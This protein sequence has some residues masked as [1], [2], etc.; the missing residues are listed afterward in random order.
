L[1]CGRSWRSSAITSS[2]LVGGSGTSALLYDQA[3]GLDGERVAPDLAA[4]GE[5]LPRRESSISSRTR[6][7]PHRHD[8]A[9]LGPLAHAVVR[10]AHDVRALAG[11]GRGL[12]LV[13]RALGVLHHHLARRSAVKASPTFCS[14]L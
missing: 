12:E 8:Q 6:G 11:G 9:G 1:P 3:D 2:K 13:G 7:R 10:P 5:G 14:P 4:V